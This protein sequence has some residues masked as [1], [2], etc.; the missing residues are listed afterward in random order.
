MESGSTRGYLGA[1]LIAG[2]VKNGTAKRA[3]DELNGDGIG[4]V[5]L[6]KMVMK[7][8]FVAGRYVCFGYRWNCK[9]VDG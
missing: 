4:V 2:P 1:G 5:Y 3:C 7:D 6:W 9:W 8:M